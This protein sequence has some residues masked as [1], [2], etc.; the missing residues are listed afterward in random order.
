MHT[1]SAES[2]L[3]GVTLTA[4]LH[5][6]VLWVLLAEMLRDLLDLS[7]IEQGRYRVDLEPHGADEIFEDAQALLIPL[8]EAE[9]DQASLFDRARP[10]SEC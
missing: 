6:L 4:L 3:V 5:L 1:M 7:T 10:G 8:A 9:T 2:R